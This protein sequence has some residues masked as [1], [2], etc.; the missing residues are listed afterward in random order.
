ME[1][2]TVEEDKERMR[3]WIDIEKR[4]LYSE[5]Q[6]PQRMKESP[7]PTRGREL[8]NIMTLEEWKGLTLLV[9]VLDSST[10]CHT[11]ERGKIVALYDGQV[12]IVLLF[13]K[14]LRKRIDWLW[15]NGQY[16]RLGLEKKTKFTGMKPDCHL[17]T[18]VRRRASEDGTTLPIEIRNDWSSD[19]CILAEGA[20]DMPITDLAATFVL[21][22]DSHF[23]ME[24]STLSHSIELVKGSKTHSHFIAERER[25]ERDARARLQRARMIRLQEAMR[26]DEEEEEM[27]R[28]QLW[29][30]RVSSMGWRELM[31]EK[32]TLLEGTKN[33]PYRADGTA[34]RQRLLSSLL[35][36]E[37]TDD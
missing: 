16:H 10:R 22:A 31:E 23:P 21:W 29:L 11:Q 14:M 17:L 7:N 25:L 3:R 13:E 1:R 26:R 6:S 32:R 12:E 8:P 5:P 34:S 19:A 30:D 18:L 9:S 35:D 27:R 4:L 2:M 15:L 33:Q 37:V 24:P 28:N 20:E 36:P